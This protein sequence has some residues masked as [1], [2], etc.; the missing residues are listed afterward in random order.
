MYWK[1]DAID[2]LK[3][4]TAKKHSLVSIPEE[5]RLLESRA[6]AIRSATADGTPVRGGGSGREDAL[7]SNVVHRCEL[8]RNL[9]QAKL[10]VQSVD[11]ALE[12][13]SD[14]ER[15]V[16]ERFYIHPARGNVDRL[17]EELNRE[18]S[19]VYERRDSALRHFTVA[20]FGVSES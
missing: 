8:E 6:T 1:Y 7:L 12:L 3:E 15:K 18:K 10:W 20:L 16:L 13:L 5:I 2:K 4:Y 11:T 17:C 14:E 19:A 9:E